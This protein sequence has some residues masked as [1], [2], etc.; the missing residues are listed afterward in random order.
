MSRLYDCADFG[1]FKVYD[2]YRLQ[3]SEKNFE[4]T[5][6]AVRNHQ[7]NKKLG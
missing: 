7:K 4:P 5:T 6:K 1:V 3:I 2:N